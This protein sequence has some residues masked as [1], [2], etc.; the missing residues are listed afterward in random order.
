MKMLLLHSPSQNNIN[1]LLTA[2]QQAYPSVT[3]VPLCVSEEP[4]STHPMLSENESD[5]DAALTCI[6]ITSSSAKS[7]IPFP[8]FTIYPLFSDILH[9]IK[10]ASRSENFSIVA[11]P[12]VLFQAR[13]ICTQMNLMCK[14]YSPADLCKPASSAGLSLPVVTDSFTAPLVQSL[15]FST[16]TI[17]PGAESLCFAIEQALAFCSYTS[18][19]CPGCSFYRNILAFSK[20]A[21]LIFSGSPNSPDV[22]QY[23]KEPIPESLQAATKNLLPLFKRQPDL[24]ALETIGREKWDIRGHL[25]AHSTGPAIPVFFCTRLSTTVVFQTP[26]I[27]IQYSP[28][29]QRQKFITAI[30]KNVPTLASTLHSLEM[31]SLSDRPL[32]IRSR[33]ADLQDLLVSFIWSKSAV[34]PLPLIQ[35]DCQYIDTLQWKDLFCGKNPLLFQKDYIYHFK[36]VHCLESSIA[37][38]I[39]VLIDSA[40]PSVRRNILL[41]DAKSSLQPSAISHLSQSFTN[42]IDVVAILSISLPRSPDKIY[43]L[44]QVCLEAFNFKFHKSVKGFTPAALQLLQRR[45]QND[46][47][48]S[49]IQTVSNIVQQTSQ[50][51]VSL[52]DVEETLSAQ[53]QSHTA[54]RHDIALDGPLSEI[55]RSVIQAVLAEEGMNQSKA[56]KRLGI[57]RSTLWRKLK[58]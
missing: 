53:L 36:N 40:S 31:L 10:L 23:A 34:S 46:Q 41:S 49:F 13:Q 39:R 8:I 19:F 57:S 56:A 18:I 5:F 58:P 26:G 22:S 7:F 20:D 14:F 9:V 52:H 38:N 43:A 4:G 50:P 1:D 33:E 29:T 17:A 35:L 15:G 12:A 47:L 3:L 42:T 27:S 6:S 28:S 2:A 48:F 30:A 51:F 16:L 54:P 24:H 37:A 21:I 45:C 55:T 11:T 32:F 25:F 44:I